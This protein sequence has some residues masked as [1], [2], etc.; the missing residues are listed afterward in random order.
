MNPTRT[1]LQAIADAHT[2]GP[3]T[4]CHRVLR[5]CAEL[6]GTL[7]AQLERELGDETT[8]WREATCA[9]WDELV[10]LVRGGVLADGQGNFGGVDEDG[11]HDAAHPKFVECRLTAAGRRALADQTPL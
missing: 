6:R 9:F 7:D 11:E 8:P 3:F 1:L 2:R 10:L 4:K 5:R